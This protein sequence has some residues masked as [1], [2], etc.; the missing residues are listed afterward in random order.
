MN[1]L[2]TLEDHKHSRFTRKG[3]TR[4]FPFVLHPLS[5]ESQ[6]GLT[7]A[8][9]IETG[10][11]EVVNVRCLRRRLCHS[12]SQRRDFSVSRPD[13]IDQSISGLLRVKSRCLA[14]TIPYISFFLA[15]YHLDYLQEYKKTAKYALL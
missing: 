7:E 8:S 9:R 11:M 2:V 14:S 12:P 6:N 13:A 15:E 1:R 4:H 5:Q 10:A 3:K